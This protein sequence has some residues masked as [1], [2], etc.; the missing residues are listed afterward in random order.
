MTRNSLRA[1]KD[2]QESCCQ[3]P[4][5]HVYGCV[6]EQ[7]P[8]FLDNLNYKIH[9]KKLPHDALFIDMLKPHPEKVCHMIIIQGVIEHLSVPPAFY[10][11]KI[12]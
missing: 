6:L 8:G 12:F 4:E 11:G 2:S 1:Q 10:K 5:Q 3:N 9:F 7:I